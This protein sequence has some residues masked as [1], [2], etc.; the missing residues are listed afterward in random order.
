MEALDALLD[1]PIIQFLLIVIIAVGVFDSFKFVMNWIWR[2]LGGK[3]DE[4]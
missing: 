3:E 2:K 1:D 4:D